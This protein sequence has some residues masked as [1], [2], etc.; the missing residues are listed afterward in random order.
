M[1]YLYRSPYFT[2]SQLLKSRARGSAVLLYP[3]C[4]VAKIQS[5]LTLLRF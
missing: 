5:M 2:R 4:A 3:Q 1:F